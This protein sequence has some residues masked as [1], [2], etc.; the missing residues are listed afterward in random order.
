MIRLPPRSTRTDTLFP[1]TT[2]FRSGHGHRAAD[3]LAGHDVEHGREHYFGLPDGARSEHH[4]RSEEHT[5]EIQS[6]M[7]ISYAVFCLNNK[8]N[9]ISHTYT[10]TNS[11]FSLISSYPLN[12]QNS[13]IYDKIP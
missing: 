4:D 11:F 8:N 9:I 13:I 2:L 3:Q 7:R 12:K 6:L 10:P 5:S 1:Y